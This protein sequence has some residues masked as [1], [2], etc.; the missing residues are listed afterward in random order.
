MQYL[1]ILEGSIKFWMEKIVGKPYLLNHI[2]QGEV[3]YG[4]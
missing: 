1:L 4:M 2:E 3:F